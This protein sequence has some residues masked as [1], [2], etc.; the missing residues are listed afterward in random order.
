MSYLS[1]GLVVGGGAYLLR[2]MQNCAEYGRYA[3]TQARCCPARLGWFLQEVPALLVPLLLLLLSAET[4]TGRR[5]LIGTFMLHYF[6]RYGLML[7][8]SRET[9][10][11]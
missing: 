7:A 11:I 3:P 5:L 4:G 9:L 6:H 2:Q 8:C 10:T 1:W